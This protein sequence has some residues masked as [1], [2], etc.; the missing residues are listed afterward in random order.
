[1]G[2]LATIPGAHLVAKI[3]SAHRSACG[4]AEKVFEYSDKAMEYAAECGRLLLE[5]KKLVPH[6]EWLP[7][8][9][10]H[11]EFGER[12]AQKY[13]RIAKNWE[14]I[15]AAKAKSEPGSYFGSINGALRLISKPRPETND[16]V[17]EEDEDDDEDEE[18]QGELEAPQDLYDMKADI[19]AELK[20][21]GHPGA[22]Y[23]NVVIF[24]PKTNKKMG[25]NGEWSVGFISATA[26][27][28]RPPERHSGRL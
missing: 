23:C 12:Q 5:A 27:T 4:N 13:T 14:K 26:C 6:G 10:A 25:G 19:Q 9:E 7:W 11:I 22:E 8:I 18:D 28:E 17:P 3:N 2:K 21:Q 24:D 1:M 16:D 20:R 15:E